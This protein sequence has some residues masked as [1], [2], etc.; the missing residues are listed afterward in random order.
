MVSQLYAVIEEQAKKSVSA[1]VPGQ[2]KIF[3]AKP[4]INQPSLHNII[5]YSNQISVSNNRKNSLFFSYF[6]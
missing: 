1:F 6:S 4:S 5:L 3:W 2:A